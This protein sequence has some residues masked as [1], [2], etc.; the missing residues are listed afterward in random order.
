MSTDEQKETGGTAIDTDDLIQKLYQALQKQ[1]ED[2]NIQAVDKTEGKCRA[3]FSA[4]RVDAWLVIA[5]NNK[6]SNDDLNSRLKDYWTATAGIS[7]LVTGFTF[8]A[9][10][11]GNDYRETETISPQQR[12]NLFGLFSVL[13]F[14]SSLFATLA[15]SLLYAYLNIIGADKTREFVQAFYWF[16]DA[17]VFCC[18]VGIVLMLISALINIGGFVAPWAYQ[19][20]FISIMTGSVFFGVMITLLQRKMYALTTQ[21]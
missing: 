6:V 14:G 1:Q 16:L 21:K 3:I 12:E 19:V 5:E 11:S 10:Q 4:L 7:A 15:C 20:I 18:F 17:P 2:D 8:I 13:S 9:S